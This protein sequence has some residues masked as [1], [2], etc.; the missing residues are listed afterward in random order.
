MTYLLTLDDG[1]MVE[2]F[3]ISSIFCV[4]LKI[5]IIKKFQKLNMPIKQILH[6]FKLKEG[7]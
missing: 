2:H 5:S 7:D 3:V 4:Y 6:I 1:Y